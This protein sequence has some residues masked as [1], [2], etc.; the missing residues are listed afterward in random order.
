[1]QKYIGYI[2]G[3]LALIAGLYG[4]YNHGYNE[5]ARSA[6]AEIQAAQLDQLTKDTDKALVDIVADN[7]T[8]A[9][10]VRIEYVTNTEIKEVVRYVEKEIVVPVGCD[11]LAANIVRVRSKATS[12]INAN[13]KGTATSRADPLL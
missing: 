5:G 13:A 10:R 8:A 3:G 4:L 7:D 9:E 1:M 2:T 12:I 11:E 6:I